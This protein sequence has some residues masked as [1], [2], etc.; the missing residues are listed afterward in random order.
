MSSK[1]VSLDRVIESMMD[2]I[3]DLDLMRDRPDDLLVVGRR[4]LEKALVPSLTIGWL[5]GH[6]HSRLIVFGVHPE[7][8]ARA[9]Y[10]ATVFP[11]SRFY[12][13]QDTGTGGFLL[14]HID[15][16]RFL[17]LGDEPVCYQKNGP[18]NRFELYCH[19]RLVG[20]VTIDGK[21]TAPPLVV[22]PSVS[23][24]ITPAF[25]ASSVD[26]VALRIW[27]EK[28]A[29][30]FAGGLTNEPEVTWFEPYDDRQVA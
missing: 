19:T 9:N 11:L 30:R 24:G 18:P 15:L 7:E 10:L 6:A 22:Q 16:D 26:R 23:I 17:A 29:V 1:F 5:V 14:E 20:F 2:A 4:L 21:P 28:T 25:R 3:S 12:T 13:L 8:N 27:A